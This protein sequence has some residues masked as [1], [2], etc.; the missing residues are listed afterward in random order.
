[1]M[2]IQEFNLCEIK[3]TLSRNGSEVAKIGVFGNGHLDGIWEG[4]G[5]GG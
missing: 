4:A 3:K 2:S 1:M 5:Q